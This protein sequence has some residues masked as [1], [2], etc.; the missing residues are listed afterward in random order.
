MYE[1]S[2]DVVTA[3]LD[4]DIE[5]E[6]DVVLVTSA[7][8]PNSRLLI[9]H[10]NCMKILGTGNRSKVCPM[11][12]ETEIPNIVRRITVQANVWIVICCSH[13]LPGRCQV[14]ELTCHV[15]S[16]TSFRGNL[17]GTRNRDI[18]FIRE[19]EWWTS[20]GTVIMSDRVLM[21]CVR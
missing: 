16:A 18:C 8:V 11:N 2:P 10:H 21:D 1:G 6:V 13:F 14:T 15:S 4:A 19:S 17:V 5:A 9:S 20:R 7:G 3:I 12:I